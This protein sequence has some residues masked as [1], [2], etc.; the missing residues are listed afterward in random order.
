[1]E[2]KIEHPVENLDDSGT[3][4]IEMTEQGD[5]FGAM[6]ARQI[7]G[8]WG[9]L[10]EISLDLDEITA[11]VSGKTGHLSQ[12]Q[13]E[14]GELHTSN[15]Q[16]AE[17][18][19]TAN[20]IA[21]EATESTAETT[22][23]VQ[24]STVSIKS[25][26]E[27]VSNISGRLGALTDALERVSGVAA[28]IEAI[29]KQTN[30]LALNATIEAA[31]AGTAGKGFAVV[32]GEVKNLSKQTSDAT[33]D[34][35]ETVSELRTQ[36]EMLST[37][38]AN[39]L[40]K[41]DRANTD[42]ANIAESMDDL[43]TIFDLLKTHVGEINE[44]ATANLSVCTHVSESLGGFAEDVIEESKRLNTANGHVSQL[45]ALSEDLIEQVVEEGIEIEDTPFITAVRDTANEI[46]KEFEAA[47]DAGEITMAD[48][49]D[50][51]YTPVS[52]SE[53]PQVMAKMVPFTDRLL[54]GIQEPLL[55]LDD[56]VTFCAA[57]DRNGYL[58]THNKQYSQTP[59]DD[60][61]WNMANCRNRR[62]FDDPTGLG[63]GRN[64]TKPF[65]LK[66]YKRDM[67]GG[68]T[69]VMKDCS[70]PITVKGRHWGG[71]RMGYK[72]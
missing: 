48:L 54:P 21:T 67:G 40:E 72:A 35:T 37:D 19:T 49:F 58:P 42:T 8:V 20:N 55:T 17:L 28:N 71:L 66:T 34:I 3:E 61:V 6:A 36:I 12:L 11:A 64:S 26:I 43:Q 46:G 38:S 52:G 33:T 5:K 30:L 59:S 57:V 39:S 24:A 16:I 7:A 2:R 31:R 45:L 9:E 13:D 27:S 14:M 51:H 18:A 29:A 62:I 47:V 4:A 32:A 25:L 41:A 10:A 44:S 56:R 70:A 15:G 53:P 50:E 22:Q 23:T 63:A 65:L 69:A 60:P 1:M 68:V